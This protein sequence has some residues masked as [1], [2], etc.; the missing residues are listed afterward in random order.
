MASYHRPGAIRLRSSQEAARQGAAGEPRKR[1]PERR[2]WAS[3]ATDASD[4]GADHKVNRS[5]QP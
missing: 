4:L 2:R 5:H 1:P 3:G